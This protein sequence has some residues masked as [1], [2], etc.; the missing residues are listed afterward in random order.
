MSRQRL[1]DCLVELI[2]S[3]QIANKDTYTAIKTKLSRRKRSKFGRFERDYAEPKHLRSLRL[4]DTDW[5]NLDAIATRNNLT[6]A[7]AIELFA[8]G[9]Q[10]NRS[11]KICIYMAESQRS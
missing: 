4:T 7:E 11:T 2:I 10:L 8:R 9:L 6:R 5:G 3:K 1:V